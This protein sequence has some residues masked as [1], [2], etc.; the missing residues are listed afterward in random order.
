MV[1]RKKNKRKTGRRKKKLVLGKLNPAQLANTGR[2]LVDIGKYAEAILYFKELYRQEA[3][4][5]S[6]LLL[7]QAYKL[8]VKE[9]ADKGMAAEALAILHDMERVCQLSASPRQMVSLLCLCRQYDK[10]VCLYLDN[11]DDFGKNERTRLDEFFAALALSGNKKLLDLFPET[12]PIRSHYPLALRVLSSFCRGDVKSALRDLQTISFRSPYCHFRL[13]ISGLLKNKESPLQA[14]QV[15]DK[16]PASSPYH[17]LIGI[18]SCQSMTIKERLEK[19]VAA[20][21]AENLSQV[22]SVLGLSGKQARFLVKLA[23]TAGQERKI[24]QLLMGSSNVLPEQTS[25]LLA[26][27]LVVYEKNMSDQVYKVIA[28]KEDWETLRLEALNREVNG[29]PFGAG[30]AW[31]LYLKS[32]PIDTPDY[33]LR[34][35]LILRR[36]ADI[37]KRIAPHPEF[38]SDRGLSYLLASVQLDADDHQV[39][40]DII[41]LSRRHKTANEAY[42][43]VNRAVELFPDDIEILLKAIEAT[44][45]R[46]AFK[47]ASR[48]AERLLEIDPINVQGQQ[49][50]AEAHFSHGRKLA[51]QKKY[52]LAEKEFSLID[53]KNRHRF[54]GGRAGI[55]LAMLA[56]AGKDRKK[57]MELIEKSREYCS[58]SLVGALLVALEGR[59]FKIAGPMLR[60]FDKS[61]RAAAKEGFEQKECSEL[62]DW[63]QK[64]RGEERLALS[65]CVQAMKSYLTRAMKI[66]WSRKEAENIAE[67]LLTAKMYPQLEK[68]AV[69]QQDIFI[70]DL[71][72]EFMQEVGACRDGSKPILWEI[73][74]SLYDMLYEAAGQGNVLLADR[75]GDFI[76]NCVVKGRGS[77]DNYIDEDGCEDEI[78]GNFFE[79]MQHIV[80]LHKNEV[81]PVRK[82]PSENRQMNLFDD[83]FNAADE[84]KE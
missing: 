9:I 69:G 17:Q 44:A 45:Q 35:A 8:R 66:S 61:L 27:K 81:K 39:W 41:Q 40:L 43:L 71:Y 63:L 70:D 50:L 67:L 10:A 24:L 2:Q 56:F 23:G 36:Q 7:A 28:N 74:D 14:Q 84:E 3:G 30:G 26:D 38:S 58:S 52:V 1:T 72:F 83:L 62:G 55:C 31:E 12:D 18:F 21:A 15:F 20:D 75:I 37:L 19:I 25:Q 33:D 54:Y 82:I 47:K 48:F 76:K 16:L 5:E 32:F 77:V 13:L 73:K 64:S 51:A 78:S 57:G 46:G 11:S 29:E 65:E 42:R 22:G 79:D 34:R 59:L 4:Q 6:R 49:L 80:E 53:L 60:E 68:F